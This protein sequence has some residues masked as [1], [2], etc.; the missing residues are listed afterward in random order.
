[1]KRNREYYSESFFDTYLAGYIEGDGYIGAPEF[2]GERF[3]SG[4]LKFP[5]I[6]IRFPLKDVPLAQLFLHKIGV[7]SLL[8]KKG[9]NAYVLTINNKES[10][11]NIIDRVY[12]WMR[13]P[14]INSLNKIISYYNQD[15]ATCNKPLAKLD[16]SDLSNNS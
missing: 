3:K 1:M 11:L 7:G 5:T 10:I 8:R 9:V 16:L 14:K 6:Q 2:F 4:R 15:P 13:T 12:P